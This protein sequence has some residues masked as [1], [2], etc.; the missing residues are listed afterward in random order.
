QFGERVFDL[1]GETANVAEQGISMLEKW[2]QK[3]KSPTRLSELSIPGEDIPA[4]ASNALSL[5]K[6]WRLKDYTQPVIEEILH[7]CL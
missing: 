7:K 2:F 3:V 5:A 1:K 6:V 4:I